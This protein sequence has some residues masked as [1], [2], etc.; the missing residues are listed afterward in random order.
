MHLAHTQPVAERLLANRAPTS[1][2]N[3]SGTPVPAVNL[4]C[5]VRSPDDVESNRARPD[6]RAAAVAAG[7][8]PALGRDACHAAMPGEPGGGRD[9]CR[10]AAPV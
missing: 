5:Q 4:P 10:L 2:E 3:E 7:L 8:P 6:G 9:R 1:P